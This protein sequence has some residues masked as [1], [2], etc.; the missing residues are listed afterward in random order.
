MSLWFK[1]PYSFD[2]SSY[3]TTNFSA[4]FRGAIFQWLKQE[5]KMFFACQKKLPRQIFQH[6][7]WVQFVNKQPAPYLFKLNYFGHVLKP[8]AVT[9]KQD[10]AVLFHFVDITSHA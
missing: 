5:S 1:V 6:I 8:Q 3:L 9:V 2:T 7:S 4:S 10:L